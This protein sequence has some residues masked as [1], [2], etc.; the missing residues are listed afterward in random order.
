MFQFI[1]EEAKRSKEKQAKPRPTG[2]RQGMATCMLRD[3]TE[4]SH[5]DRGTG[6]PIVLVH[7]WAANATFFEDLAVRLMGEHRVIVPTLRAHPG[8]GRGSA[9]LSIET[10]GSDLAELFERLQLTNV[11]AL[12]WSMGAMALWAAMPR[13]EARVS[14]LIVE[15]MGAHLV[16]DAHGAHG[17]A[18]GYR[19]SDVATTLSDMRTNWPAFVTRFA[20]RIFAPQVVRQRPDLVAWTIS[21][22][23]AADPEAM[24][25]FWSSMA[26]QDFRADLAELETPLL[27]VHGADNLIYADAATD[28]VACAARRGRRVVIPDAGHAPHIEAPNRFFETVVAFAREVNAN[29]V[30]E[31]G[32]GQ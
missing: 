2:E 4:L 28:L 12:G 17:L 21:E 19:L 23:S 22:M 1:A 7:G 5:T 24:A 8:S 18:G 15:D 25:A 3:G 6:P 16:S 30:L 10:L 26:R 11:V 31:G 14:G 27:V 32:R 9:P 13:I 20:P 29:G